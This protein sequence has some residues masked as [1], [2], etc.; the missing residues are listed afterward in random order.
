MR[1][2]VWVKLP[3]TGLGNKLSVW[4]RA[5]VFATTH[6]LKLVTTGWFHISL[7]PML[8][9]E[10][11][12]RLYINYFKTS[13][14]HL[15]MQAFIIKVFGKIIQNPSFNVPVSKHS[16]CF[17]FNKYE[18]SFNEIMP[19]RHLIISG[20][21]QSLHPRIK[22]KLNHCIWPEIAVHIRRGDFKKGSFITPIEYYISIINRIRRITGVN[23]I[24]HVYSDAEDTELKAL[25]KLSNV[26][27]VK[28][29]EDILD[30]IEMSRSK[31]LIT[32]AHSTFSYWACFL[33]EGIAIKHK[34]EWFPVL[35]PIEEGQFSKEWIID[36]E[37]LF[38]NIQE[39]AIV[40]ALQQ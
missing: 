2:L 1:S 28:K 18:M 39:E 9:R 13:P 6:N 8:R 27:R 23:H 38:N 12:K 3:P 30:L 22:A 34:E 4:A 37:K 25:L 15:L 11:S 35:R 21:M 5:Y 24:V 17:I 7:G 36:Q 19:H 26:I 16:E 33:G 20:L 10:R 40:R 14:L 31:V 32:A 29:R